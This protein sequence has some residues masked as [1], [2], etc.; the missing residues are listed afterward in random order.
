LSK[1][2]HL[3]GSFD[4]DFLWNYM[5]E[6]PESVHCLPVRIIPPWDPTRTL[7]IRNKVTQCKT[8][9][10]FRKLCTCRGYRSLK[11]ML[12]CFEV[13]LPLVRGNVDL[14]EQLSF[15]FCQRQW[16]QNVVYCE[17]RYSPHLLAKAFTDDSN[18]GSDTAV[19]DNNSTTTI[20]RSAITPDEVF[21]AVTRVYIQILTF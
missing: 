11:E 4:A 7:N 12:S 6:N 13:F 2:Q 19:H 10:E 18:T 9:Q 5:K 21:A 3:D 8:A 1:K 17:V 16:E 14:I 15:D 20:E